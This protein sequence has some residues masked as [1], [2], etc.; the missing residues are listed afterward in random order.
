[1]SD[2]H[3]SETVT[4]EERIKAPVEPEAIPEA[5]APEPEAPAAELETPPAPE[6]EDTKPRQD[7]LIKRVGE[8]TAKR[9]EAEAKAEAAERRA[10]AAEAL[11]A[12]RGTPEPEAAP[13]L[14]T[15]L[16]P[17][18]SEFDAAVRAETARVTAEQEYTRRCNAMADQGTATHGAE[19]QN[20]IEAFNN[21]GLVSD[22]KFVGSI[23]DSD[24]PA[25]V[26]N[27]LGQ[28]P[29]IALQMAEMP[30]AK[31]AVAF[32]RIIRDLKTPKPAPAL[33]KAPAPI[34]PVGG[35]RARDNVDIYSDETSPEDY[36]AE[37]ERAWKRKNG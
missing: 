4:D 2:D 25:D 16:A 7:G 35:E 30:D 15:A 14:S 33:S 23:L 12:A 22:A 32:D 28:N 37:R 17:G 27:Y 31:R 20:S 21:L 29:E 5:A 6:G 24:A 19:F 18:S 8:L 36:F 10:A 26:F 3:A 9:R 1:M 11:L 13:A 34:S